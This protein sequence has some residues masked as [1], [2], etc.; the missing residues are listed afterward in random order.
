MTNK[1]NTL[2][3]SITKKPYNHRKNH[4]LIMT[5]FHASAGVSLSFCAGS[6][7][8]FTDGHF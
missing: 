8:G 2:H 5:A 3:Y 6:Q 4:Q 7:W 1:L